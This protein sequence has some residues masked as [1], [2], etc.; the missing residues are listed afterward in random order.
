M[1]RFLLYEQKA[2]LHVSG[3][4]SS[5]Y[6]PS[7]FSCLSTCMLLYTHTY[8]SSDS[9]R[10][11]DPFDQSLWNSGRVVGEVRNGKRMH[12]IPNSMTMGFLDGK[13]VFLPSIF[14]HISFHPVLSIP[15]GQSC[16]LLSCCCSRMEEMSFRDPPGM[17]TITCM[18]S[19]VKDIQSCKATGLYLRMSLKCFLPFP[20]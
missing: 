14:L 3:I 10:F 15:V 19:N 16:I 12:F 1:W 11:P 2:L 13:S 8:T 6:L 9:A 7:I 4:G 18:L 17:L 5:I 20:I